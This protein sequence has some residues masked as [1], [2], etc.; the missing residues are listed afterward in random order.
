MMDP[1][2]L[3]LETGRTSSQYYSSPTVNPTLHAGTYKLSNVHVHNVETC[4]FYTY[5]A[6]SLQHSHE[7]NAIIGNHLQS[8]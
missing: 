2:Q 5:W 7:W 1:V 4:L 6:Y 3:L 8:T